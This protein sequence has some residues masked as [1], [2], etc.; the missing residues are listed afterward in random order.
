MEQ[1]NAAGKPIRCKAAVSKAPGQPLEIEEVEVAPPRAH[2]VRLKIICTS[3]CHTDITFWRMKDFPGMFPSILGHE[4]VG[5]VESVGDHVP[6]Q[7]VAVGDTVVP[8]FLA[9]CGECPDCLSPRSNICSALPYRPGGM[10]RD[11]TTRF[12]LAATGEPVHGFL[13]VSSFAEYTVVDVAHV[14]KLPAAA[15]P[16]PALPPE[17]ACLL[18]CGVATGVGA[19]WK[20]AAVESGSTVAVFGL[21]AVGLAVAQGSKMRGANRIIGVDLNPDKFEIGKKL[22]VTD[23]VNPNDIGDKN[24]SEVIKEMTGGAGADYCFECIGSVSVMAEAFKSSRMGWGKT[25]VL[26]VDGSAAPISVSS[27]DI[28]RGRSVVG[29]L[30]GGI[31]PKDDIPVLAH[32]YLDKARTPPTPPL[33]LSIMRAGLQEILKHVEEDPAT[34]PHQYI[35]V[36]DKEEEAESCR[37]YRIAL[38][39]PSHLLDRASQKLWLPVTSECATATMEQSAAAK[40]IRC[41]GM[42]PCASISPAPL[43][44]EQRGPVDCRAAAVSKAPGQPLEMEEVEVAPP[45]EHEVRVKIIC[46]SLCHTDVTFWRMKDFPSMYPS[47]LGHEAV[48][49]VESVGHHVQEVAVGDTVVPVFLA[50]CGG[51]DDCLSAR[52]NICSAVAYRPGGMPRD[53]TTRFSLAATGE[54]VHSFLSVSSFAEYTVVDVAHVVKLGPL[55]PPEKACLLSC[56]VTTGV[57]AAWKVAAVEPGSTVAVFG[58]GT[59]GLAVAQGAKMRGAKRIIGVDL[60]QEKFDIGIR[61]LIAALAPA[62]SKRLGVTDF[63]NPNETGD[64]TVSEVITEMTGGG[65]DHCFECIGSVSVMAEAFQSSRKGWGKTIILGTAAGAAPVS[66]SSSDIKRGRSVTGAL[67]GGIK[68]KD[69]IPVLAQNYLNKELQLDEFITHQMGF[70]EINRAFDLLEQGKC[71]RCIIWMD[72]A[73]ETGGVGA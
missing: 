40:P 34:V 57:G 51:C 28:M 19:A 48:G 26:G 63:V 24:V 54:P 12:S 9:Q 41:R 22:G 61:H 11:G 25:V 33:H 38:V 17:M 8:V 13:C 21:G 56:G 36:T 46:T 31:K 20:V 7:E 50:Q 73:K 53:G 42:P 35:T 52:S 3:L 4:A 14:V 47:I 1:S 69:D 2:E 27:L 65:A 44:D 58:L 39:R 10:P 72:G 37:R 5:V 23:F 59:V 15:G 55:L 67:L 30:F 29:S 45:R 6:E 66:I 71:L 32:K 16:E 18:S 68:P 70:D 43:Y 60:N 64:K 49:V 62:Y